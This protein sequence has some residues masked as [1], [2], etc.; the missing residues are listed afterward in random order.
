MTEQPAASKRP[1]VLALGLMIAG[2]ALGWWAVSSGWITIEESLLGGGEAVDVAATSLVEISGSRFAPVASAA[3]IIG[4]AGIAGVIGSRGWLRRAIGGVVV[5]AGVVL[6][7]S[8]VSAIISASKGAA[9]SSIG[10]AGVEGEVVSVSLL[11]PVIA[12]VAGLFL[13]VGGAMTVYAGGRWSAL[14]SGY[15]RAGRQPRDDWE[16]LDSGIDPTLDP[17]PDHTDHDSSTSAPTD[18]PNA[19][20][21]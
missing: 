7:W 9:T 16:A 3:P 6:A 5:A 14:G 21:K 12:M 18:R 13:A 1:Y 10:L 8:G 11:Y 2:S 20:G 19:A 4:L 15:E 17:T